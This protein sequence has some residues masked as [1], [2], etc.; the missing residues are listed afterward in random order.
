MLAMLGS[1]GGGTPGQCARAEPLAERREIG[2]D[3]GRGGRQRRCASEAAPGHER[4]PVTRIEPQ[5][6]G[7]RRT[8]EAAARRADTLRQPCGLRSLDVPRRPY[9]SLPVAFV[10]PW[11]GPASRARSRE[12]KRFSPLAR[13]RASL[14]KAW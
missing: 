8:P 1:D 4:R 6:F 5:C 12:T 13:I 11:P 10:S 2:S 14:I 3:R 9:P 7:G